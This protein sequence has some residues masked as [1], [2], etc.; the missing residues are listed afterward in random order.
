M[1]L[2]W[3]K[4]EGE[5]KISLLL[6]TRFG[7]AVAV[8]TW[9]T[10]TWKPALAEAGVIPPRA[11]EAKAWQWAAVPKDGFHVLRHTYASIMLGAGE[12]VVTL[13]RWLGR[14]SSAIT[15]GYY[16]HFMP[17]AGSKGRGAIDGLLG[18][19]ETGSPAETP[20]ILPSAV[21]R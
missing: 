13:A 16:A 5:K 17:E 1:E 21:D 6:T 15:L 20:Q 12:S 3:G 4:P 19:G 7:N 9:N 11:E 14:S 18:S 10:Y 8:N 2:P